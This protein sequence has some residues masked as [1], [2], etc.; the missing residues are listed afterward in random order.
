MIEFKKVNEYK[1]E[2]LEE[3]CK[4]AVRQIREKAYASELSVLGVEN[5]TQLGIAF[6]GK[7]VLVME[8]N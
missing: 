6:R 5:V 1:G 4:A 2:T 3:A 7:E 8:G